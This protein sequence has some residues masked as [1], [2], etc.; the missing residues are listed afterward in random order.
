MSSYRSIDP[1]LVV[2]SGD[3]SGSINSSQLDIGHLTNA[4]FEAVWTGS[5]VGSFKVEVS[6]TGNNWADLGVSISDAAG[7]AGSRVVNISGLA[8]KYIRFVYT[9][10]SG[11]GTLNVYGSARGI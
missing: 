11:T 6:L 3:M 10:T 9:F 7:S 4:A 2:T 5:P 1:V 8:V